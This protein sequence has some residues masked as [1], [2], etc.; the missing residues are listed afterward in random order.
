MALSGAPFPYDID[1]LL[2]GAVR[3]LIADA[4]QAIPTRI[5][6]VMDQEAPYAAKTGW[7]DL[8]ATRESFS[9]TRGF[10][11]E[12]YE[13]QQVAG[14]VIEEITDI[15]RSIE[16]SFAEFN[17]ENLSLIENAPDVD[18]LAA[19]AAAA[20]VGS[21]SPLTNRVAFGSFKSISRYRFAFVSQRSTVS[22]TVTETTG[23]ERGRF[24]MGAVYQAQIAADEVEIE[25]AKGELTAAGVSFTLFPD[26]T[27]PTGEE[28]GAWYDEQP[29]TIT[30]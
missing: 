13:I 28:Y 5:F 26:T 15:A 20:A 25:Q 10:D 6:D 24:F 19:S 2:G 8:G 23:K 18:V 29:G 30:T 12:G 1:N 9:Y 14:N 3:I 17:G 16:V 7:R 22:G 27:Q 11:T 21:R 4:D